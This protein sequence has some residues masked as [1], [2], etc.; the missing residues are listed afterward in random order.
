MASQRHHAVPR[1]YLKRFASDDGFIWLHD[2]KAQTA[3]RVT[4]SNAIVEKF[5][6]SPEAGDNPKDDTFEQFLA[7][8]V[9]SPAAPALQRLA[10]GDS[11]SSDDRQRIAV[12]LAFQ[13]FRIP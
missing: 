3:V 9:E 4:P 6:Y 2:I 12:F 11:I 1:F 7:Q 13:E 8:H 5:L 10:N